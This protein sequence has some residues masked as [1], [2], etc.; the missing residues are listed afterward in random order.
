MSTVEIVEA[1]AYRQHGLLLLEASGAAWLTFSRPWWDAASW[2][3]FW[4]APGPKKWVHV[5]R[6]DGRKVRIRAVR[7]AKTHVRIG[8]APC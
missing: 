5:R 7:L 2:L 6:E 3:W 4:L 1:Q 8:G